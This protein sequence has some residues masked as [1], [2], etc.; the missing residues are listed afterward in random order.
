MI[1][2]YL[3]CYMKVNYTILS[4]FT[5]K[6]LHVVSELFSLVKMRLSEIIYVICILIWYLNTQC[7]TIL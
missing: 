5:A 1:L 3:I 7:S 6:I 4:L 2:G